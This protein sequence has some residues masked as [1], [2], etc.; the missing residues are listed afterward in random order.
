MT[1]N[2]REFM[3]SDGLAPGPK[4]FCEK[5]RHRGLYIHVYEYY[6]VVIT[7]PIRADIE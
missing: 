7:A 6:I 5:I 3:K 1:C 2:Y 4:W